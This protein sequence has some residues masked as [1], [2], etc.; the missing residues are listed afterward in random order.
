M[1]MLVVL[2]A[3]AVGAWA[4][5]EVSGWVQVRTSPTW[6]WG[7][8][9]VN[10]TGTALLAGLIV[11]H[12]AGLVG[13]GWVTVAGTGFCGAFTTFSTWMVEAVRSGEEAGRAGKRAAVASLAGQVLAGWLLAV[14]IL[15]LA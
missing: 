10:L 8:A 11:A 14:A 9:V 1:T 15:G 13:P 4:R 12:Q 6:P 3:G 7:T 5:Y 2:L